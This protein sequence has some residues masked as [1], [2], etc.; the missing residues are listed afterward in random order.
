L[1]VKRKASKEGGRYLTQL[2][3]GGG[4][5]EGPASLSTPNPKK[6]SDGGSIDCHNSLRG[7]G[8]REL[9]SN[10]CRKRG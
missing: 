2:P 3:K 7:E 6:R 10:L 5:V 1:S 9:W 8:G 4:C